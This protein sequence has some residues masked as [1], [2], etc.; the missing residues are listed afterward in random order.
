[1]RGPAL[2][3]DHVSL[4]LGGV[5]ILE[6]VTF[7]VEAGALHFLVG[8]NGGG[9]T[10]LVRA[11]LGQ[12]PHSGK[13]VLDGEVFGPIGYVPQATEFDRNLPMTVNDVMALLNQRRPAF[14]GGSRSARAESAEALKRTGVEVDGRRPFGGL[15]GGERQRVLLAQALH[16]APW[17]LVL[18]EPA[19]GID[20]RGVRM[21]EEVV[22]ELNKRGV[23][24]LWINHNLEQVKRLATGVTIIN[25]RLRFH[26][27]PATMPDWLHVN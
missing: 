24:V 10:S 26:G 12:M 1:M 19:T 21:V 18:D 6:D 23:T 2:V 4:Q 20:E 7:R 8:P 9:K 22:A 11:L 16:P 15:S 3:F 25:G 5:Q 14:L 27:A 13:I 17:L